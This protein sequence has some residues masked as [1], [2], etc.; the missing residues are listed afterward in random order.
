GRERCDRGRTREGG[1][2][3]RHELGKQMIF[4]RLKRSRGWCCSSRPTKP[5]SRLALSLLPKAATCS[6]PC[7]S[8][9]RAKEE[10]IMSKTGCQSLPKERRAMKEVSPMVAR[11]IYFLSD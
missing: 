3:A 1:T 2:D 7:R 9:T 8:E 5:V 4:F 6:A 11:K 10:I